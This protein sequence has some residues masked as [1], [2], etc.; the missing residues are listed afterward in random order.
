M[1][2]ALTSRLPLLLKAFKYL[3]S[4]RIHFKPKNYHPPN[5]FVIPTVKVYE[6]CQK[7][8]EQTLSMMMEEEKQ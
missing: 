4:K 6:K 3:V 8:E 1:Q 2:H 5:Y 7:E